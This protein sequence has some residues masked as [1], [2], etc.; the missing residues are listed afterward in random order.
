MFKLFMTV[1][2]LGAVMSLDVACYKN[3]ATKERS[4]AELAAFYSA[5]VDA[6][7]N[8][9]VE[10]FYPNGRKF[11]FMGYSGKPE[12]DLTNGFTVAGAV[13]GNQ[14]PYLEKCFEAGWPVLAHVGPKV[15]FDDKAK[16]KYKIDE[17]SLRATVTEQVKLL[18]PHKEILW[19]G[20]HPEELRPWRTDEMKYL[21]IVCD[22]VRKNDPLNRPIYLYNPNHRNSGSLEPVAKLVDVI[23]KGCYVNLCGKKR[24]RAWVR[25]SME[26]ECDV[27]NK[28]GRS[29]AFPILMPELCKDPEPGEESEIAGWV[30]HDVYLGM[31]SGA[32][33]VNIWSLFKRTEVKKTYDLWYNAYAE[34]AS[35]LTGKKALAQIF[36]FGEQRSDLKVVRN[37]DHKSA[38]LAIG[39]AAEPTTTNEQER[40][41]KKIAFAS[42]SSAELAYGKSRYLF[43][44]NS[45]NEKAEF[46][47]SGWP[48][49]SQAVNVFTDESIPLAGE[50][51]NFK[52]ELLAYGVKALRFLRIDESR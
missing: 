7:A 26:Q 24:E 43:I 8:L 46:T 4:N 38:L 45:A 51:G 41:A 2:T 19:W 37:D 13:Y 5:P 29:G 17:P 30:R 39:G 34:C 49:G 18:A 35:E 33:A 32:K 40:D 44:V 28:T 12:R 23:A 50:E 3:F 52:I 36:L 15:T 10:G 31:I 47:I 27:I 48:K 1:A 9:P 20:V 6:G 11:A 21:E 14:M 22:V 25:W 16:D 42:W